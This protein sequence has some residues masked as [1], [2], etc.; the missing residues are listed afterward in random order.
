MATTKLGTYQDMRDFTQTAEPSG[1]NA[2]VVPSKALRFVIQKHAASHLHFDLRLEH[3]GAFRS[4]AVPKGPSL[5]PKDRRLAMEVE[6]HPLDYGDF[7]GTI[8]KG[9]YGGGTVMLW[10]RGY[11]APEK[12][13]EAISS[14]LAKGELKF[15]MEGERM[16]GSWVLV[17]LKN[18]KIGKAKNSWMLIKHRDEGAV[19]GNVGGP[20]DE[21]QSVASKRTMTQITD[22]KRRV[23]KPFMTAE[24][25]DAG[26]VW[27][28]N[29]SEKAAPSSPVTKS[30][31]AASG[32]REAS[33]ATAK[34]P[35]VSTLPAFV[36]PQL[37]KSSEKPP[38]GQ[39]WAHEIKFDGY[40][41][42]LRTVNGKATLKTRKGLDWSTRFPEIVAAGA[43]LKDGILDGEVVALDKTGAP[44]FAA[45]QAA[46]SDGKT[47]DLVFFVFDMLFQGREDLRPLP[48]AE[49]KARLEAAVADAPPNLRY[50]DHF[51]TAGDAVLLSACRMDL[52][53]IVSKRLDAPYQSGR[54]E[55]WTKSKCRQGHEV[56]IAGWTTTGDAFRSLIAGVYR[57]GALAHVGRIGTG[58]GRDTVARIMPR[59]QALET[60][61]SPFKGKG[62]PKKAAGVHWVRPELVA[63]IEYAGFTGDGSIRQAAFKG[64]REDK[65]AAEVEA[66]VPA[67]AATTELAEPAPVTVKTRTVT[68]RDSAV[69]AG[70]TISHADKVL[71]PDAGDGQPVTKKDLAEYYEAVGEWMLRHVKGRPCSRIRMPDGIDGAQKFFQ[72][73]SGKGQS[74][75]ITEVT[76]WGDR[77]PYLQFDRVEALVAAGQTG[78]LELHPWNNEPSAPEQP[79]RLV[80]DLDPAPNVD[81]DEV[82]RSAREVRDRLADLGLVSFCKTTGGKGLH[83]VTPLKAKGI[84]WSTAKAFARDVCKAM[85]NDAPDRY[86]ITM[87]KKDRTGRIFLDYL[88]NDRMATAVAPLSPRGRPGAPVSMPLTWNQVKKGLDPTRY[89]VRSVPALVR[90]LSAWEDYCEGERP[91][92]LAIKRL[93]KV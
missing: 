52:E 39:T 25:P 23:V 36:E 85:A 80:F 67:P 69:V 64:L 86:L 15:V 68:P 76:V 38:V 83:V 24:G 44:D 89:T 21:D 41:M 51:V 46:I 29:R 66:E 57:D 32:K 53:G 14:A 4:W 1:D 34:G 61:E 59:L 11:W 45:L 33:Q 70:I 35:T 27:Q 16:H 5:E 75:L 40:R 55:S 12:G 92:A 56:V 26:A 90:K 47:G 18:D 87:A 7:E 2:R 20:D 82:I 49:R 63:E 42:Q 84:D 28:S 17:R 54:S 78:A 60:D 3:D 91:L 6:D 88:R 58:Y 19:E 10:D 79:G 50:V 48:L 93:G 31:K 37:T 81:F 72:R 8:P 22:G 62:A 74:S 43:K 65:P 77:Q 71:W 30:A 73:H 13:F 9:Q